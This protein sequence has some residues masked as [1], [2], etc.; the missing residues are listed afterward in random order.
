[1]VRIPIQISSR[2]ALAFKNCI[3][4]HMRKL[5]AECHIPA[6]ARDKCQIRKHYRNCW[7][8]R[9]KRLPSLY[10]YTYGV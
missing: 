8:D 9:L 10:F 2:G 3:C 1:M 7:A 6:G 4:I 5:L